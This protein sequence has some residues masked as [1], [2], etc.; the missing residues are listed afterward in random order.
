MTAF[1]SDIHGNM[2]ALEAVLD[3]IDRMGCDKVICLGDICGYYCMI[4]E[5]IEI[6]RKREIYSLMGNHD[7]Y[8]ISG[9]CCDSKTVKMCIDYQRQI[10]TDSNLTWIQGLTP[11][12]DADY[13]SIRHG[14]WEDPLEERIFG[15]DFESVWD[16]KQKIF[17]SGHTHVQKLETGGGRTY[18]NPGSVGQPRDGDARAAFAVMDE[19]LHIYLYRVAYD[20]DRIVEEMKRHAQGDWIW[21]WLY[22]GKR[23]GG[24]DDSL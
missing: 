10:I 15:F 23:I 13:Y 11:Q 21:K 12:Y 3:E 2:P 6:L 18:C 14:G 7:Y 16:Y 17:F 9:M 22:E 4:N 1:I 20:I 19:G 8:M 5:C 24:Q